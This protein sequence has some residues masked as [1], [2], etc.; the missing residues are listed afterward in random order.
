MN[1]S[2]DSPSEDPREKE[3]SLFRFG[4]SIHLCGF[5][6]LGVGAWISVHYHLGLATAA[7]AIV[8]AL[9]GALIALGS[10]SMKDLPP[11]PGALL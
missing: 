9:G 1:G 2:F 8:F 3:I 11:D 6:S 4:F 10:V 7:V 5:A